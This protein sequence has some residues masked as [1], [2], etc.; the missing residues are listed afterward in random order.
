MTLNASVVDME[1]RDNWNPHETKKKKHS[2]DG[3]SYDV[4]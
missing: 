3:P 1:V 2:P 4:I